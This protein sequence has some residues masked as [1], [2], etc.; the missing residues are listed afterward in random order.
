MER[1]LADYSRGLCS[2]KAVCL[3]NAL[4][5][6]IPSIPRESTMDPVTSSLLLD[7]GVQARLGISLCSWCLIY[8]YFKHCN[9]MVFPL[10]LGAL[11]NPF[12]EQRVRR[13]RRTVLTKPVVP[14]ETEPPMRG[15]RTRLSRRGDP[16]W[17]FTRTHAGV[18]APESPRPADSAR[19]IALEQDL[20]EP[21]QS[22]GE[23]TEDG[24]TVSACSVSKRL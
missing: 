10:P 2:H 11:T 14:F 16:F 19:C 21:G 24:D 6:R 17:F 8:K 7:A 1:R 23:S 4:L 5:P 15:G 20:E 12:A 9:S 13:H 3:S 18:S 22:H